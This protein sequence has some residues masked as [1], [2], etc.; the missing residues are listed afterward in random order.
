M[1][2]ELLFVVVELFVL[3]LVYRVFRVLLVTRLLFPVLSV[4]IRVL[5]VQ[6]AC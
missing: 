6:S 1:L 2:V 3:C 5:T 4:L